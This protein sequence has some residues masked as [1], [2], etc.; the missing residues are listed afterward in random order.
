LKVSKIDSTICRSGLKNC[1][2]GRLSSAFAGRVEQVKAAAGQG[3][4]EAGAEVVLAADEDLAGQERSEVGAGRQDVQ[5]DLALA[6]FGARE[7][8]AGGQAV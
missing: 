3:G 6:G 8:E 2:P 7:R 1:D 5:Q 4:L